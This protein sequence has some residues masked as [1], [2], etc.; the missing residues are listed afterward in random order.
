MTNPL[1]RDRILPCKTADWPWTLFWLLSA[2]IT[3]MC[4]SVQH[5]GSNFS[6]YLDL[7]CLLQK[8]AS[9]HRTQQNYL[10]IL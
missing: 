2:E 9:D 1:F 4:H 8:T 5:L 10:R 6:E 7:S 3:G